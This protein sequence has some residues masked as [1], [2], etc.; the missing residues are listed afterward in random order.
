VGFY[1]NGGA[2][3]LQPQ[4]STGLAGFTLQNATPG[5]LSWTA[6]N[7]GQL[8]RFTIFGSIH[9]TSAETGGQ[10][11]VNYTLPDGSTPSHTLFA[12]GLGVGD[13]T[14]ALNLSIPIKPGTTVQINQNTVLSA[15]AAIMWAEIWGS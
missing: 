3:P 11:T 8:H 10:I 15:G 5:I 14:P 6:P 7:D 12:A 13:S 9:V 4:A 2:A 1:P